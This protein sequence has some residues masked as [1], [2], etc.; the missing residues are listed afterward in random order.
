VLLLFYLR[1]T[2]LPDTFFDTNKYVIKTK[3]F[4]LKIDL[5][6]EKDFPSSRLTIKLTIKRR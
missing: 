5:K 6:E 4:N 3:E 2:K 1:L